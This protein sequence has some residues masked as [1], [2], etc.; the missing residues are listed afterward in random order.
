LVAAI[1]DS[2]RHLTADSENLSERVE[3]VVENLIVVG[4]LLELSQVTLD[5]S[6]VKGTWVFAAP[7]GFVARADG[8]VFIIGLA[9][10]E[11]EPL[12]ATLRDRIRHEGCVRIIRPQ[13]S[14]ALAPE[15]R[16][17]GFLETSENAW[18]KAPK[19]QTPSE[20]QD[21]M[22][23]RLRASPP[24]GAIEELTI[25]GSSRGTSFYAGRWTKPKN[26][27]GY[28]I[29][30]RPQAYGAPLWG[31]VALDNGQPT[32]IL[33]FPLK[34]SSWRGCDTAWHLQMAIDHFNGAPQTYLRRQASDATYLDFFS[35]LPLWAQRRLSIFGRQ[36]A[37]EK[38]LLTFL[39]RE[40]ELP[41]EEKFLQERL[42]LSPRAASD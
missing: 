10:D 5:D 11:P 4:D 34:G 12:P 7:P 15:L 1:A 26:E 8:S 37:P 33:D 13:D 29:S 18:L 14:G 3:A 30:R 36:V 2:L 39:I 9:R 16:D 42:W 21:D 20:L 32:H 27:A 6:A 28:F 31:F 23:R 38:C 35:P 22:L 24:S 25:L 40:A 19:P 17:L 41:G